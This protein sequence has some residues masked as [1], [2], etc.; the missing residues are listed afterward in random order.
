MSFTPDTTPSPA[1]APRR[2]RG[3]RLLAGSVL[4]AGLVL[5]APL[6]A[7]AHVTV[8]PDQTATAGSYGVLT[9]A[10]SHGCDGSPTTALEIE[11]PDG[12]ASVTPTIEPGWQLEIERDGED[13]PVSRV[14][15]TA[16]EPV[17]S[18]LRA[19]VELGVQYA[20]DAA[21]QT[22]AFPV[23]QVCEV[24]NTSWSE[25]AEEGEDAHELDAPAPLVTVSDAAAA[26][27][28]HH[29]DS[30]T[31]ADTADAASADDTAAPVAGIVLGA[32]GAVL[33]AV[34]LVVAIL[35]LRRRS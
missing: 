15:Y 18:G 1:R 2:R 27:D 13:G 11:I 24:G 31:A 34:A 7:Q 16:D 6:A 25:L 21:G 22:L 4:A 30:G 8:S 20:E 35:A 3:G 28:A 26:D 32:A 33:G 29:D 17:E 19:T 5:A 12:L 10:F 9:F 23:N 14:V